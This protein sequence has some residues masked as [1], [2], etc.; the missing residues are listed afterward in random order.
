MPSKPARSRRLLPGLALALLPL[1]AGCAGFYRHTITT[2]NFVLHGNHDLEQLRTTGVFIDQVIEAYRDEFPR[3]AASIPAPRIVLS[4]SKLA[5]RRIFTDEKKQEG[6]YLPLFRLIH[7]SPEGGEGETNEAHVLIFHELAHHF[8][9]SAY[10]RTNSRYWLNEGF[11]CSLELSFFDDAGQLQMPL[12]HPWLH[13]QAR[14][15]LRTMGDERFLKEM[16]ELLDS[17]WFRFHRSSQKARNYAMAWALFDA[18]LDSTVGTL[19]ECLEEVLALDP[20]ELARRLEGVPNRLRESTDLRLHRLAR[21]PELRMWALES[22]LELPSPYGPLLLSHVLGLLE[23]DS[24]IPERVAGCRFLI[25]A[26][27]RRLWGVSASEIAYY[28][29]GLAE[30][31]ANGS[32]AEQLTIAE[33]LSPTTRH[34]A[35][36]RP[37]VALL[38]TDDPE[39]RVAA[40]RALSRLEEKRTIVRPAFWRAAPVQERS[41]EIR[42]WQ[43]WI[44]K[45][46]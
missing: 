38:E 41:Q 45:H 16:E 42:E 12:Y 18:C 1:V 30:T 13:L 17:S 20:N 25:R 10:P 27:D 21:R 3:H 8:L 31:L 28:H 35:Y 23:A 22:W 2:D 19:E 37:L 46:G 5:R 36:L 7:L 34:P 32:R 29:R 43:E 44:K 4:E 40:A 39:L 6:Y 15:A 33:S 14:N 26:L 24:T 11:A 9:I